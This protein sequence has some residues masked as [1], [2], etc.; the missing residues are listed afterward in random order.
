MTLIP[1][2]PFDIEAVCEAIR[3][4]H[5]HGQAAGVDRGG[6]RGGHA[7]GGHDGAPVGRGRRVRPRAPR[8]ASATRVAEEIE[9]RTGFET[10]VTTLGHVQRGGTPTAFDRVLA[11]RFGVAA[12]DAV[13]DG[14]L[15]TMVALQAGSIVRV[16]L[17]EAV[18]RA[19]ARRP[20]ALRRGPGVLRVAAAR[21]RSGRA[22]SGGGSRP[23]GAPAPVLSSDR[24]RRRAPRHRPPPSTRN[25]TWRTPV[26]AR[27]RSTRSGR[28]RCAAPAPWIVEQRSRTRSIDELLVACDRASASSSDGV[29]RDR[30]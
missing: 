16:P 26:D 1:E 11:T 23:R 5:E 19:Q 3:H 13:H 28:R 2:E 24:R 12:I 14:A 4:R 7:Q 6:G 22:S 20:R 29:G 27:W 9:A 18:G 25:R 17:A 10:R 15:G 30:R 21:A 8:A